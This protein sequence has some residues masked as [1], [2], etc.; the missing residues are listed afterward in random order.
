MSRERSNTRPDLV[1]KAKGAYEFAAELDRR[2][3]RAFGAFVASALR[4]AAD[5]GTREPRFVCWGANSFATKVAQEL[6]RQRPGCDPIL[7]DGSPQKAGLFHEGFESAVRAPVSLREAGEGLIF[8]LC[9]PSWNE[10]IAAQVKAMGFGK[11]EILDVI[12]NVNRIDAAAPG[13][14]DRELIPVPRRI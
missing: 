10:E 3:S 9:S 11:S 7:V 2:E 8:F 5:R 14:A 4:E 13:A 1:A 6:V 12:T